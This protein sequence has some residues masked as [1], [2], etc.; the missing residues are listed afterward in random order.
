MRPPAAY[1]LLHS[2][3]DPTIGVQANVM[4]KR[5]AAGM[6]A[7]NQIARNRCLDCNLLL[8]ERQGVKRCLTCQ[9]KHKSQL[10]M[11]RRKVHR[12]YN[13]PEVGWTPSAHS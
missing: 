8:A 10:N 2:I 6:G 5:L 3:Y 7:H 13:R 11:I 4:V 9:A 1:H 12:A